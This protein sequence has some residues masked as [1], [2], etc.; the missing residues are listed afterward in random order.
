[1]RHNVSSFSCKSADN[2]QIN[3]QNR[4]THLGVLRF[5]RGVGCITSDYRVLSFEMVARGGGFQKCYEI[6]V[7]F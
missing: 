4:N 5:F 2:S 7:A 1:M 6:W 3:V